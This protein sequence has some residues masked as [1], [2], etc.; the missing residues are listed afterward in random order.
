MVKTQSQ[1]RYALNTHKILSVRRLFVFFLKKVVTLIECMIYCMS[2]HSKEYGHM[3]IRIPSP[4]TLQAKE[5]TKL[6]FHKNAEGKCID[7]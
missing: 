1:E 4:Q 5:L 6:N 3:M 7:K 2:A